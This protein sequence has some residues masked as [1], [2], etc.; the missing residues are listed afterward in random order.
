[1][2]IP[3]FAGFPEQGFRFLR[4]L[5]K[6]NDRDW[7]RERKADY[8]KYVEDPMKQLVMAV[9]ESCRERGLPLH[10]KEKQPVFRV[11]R[12]IRFSKDKSPYKTHVGAE[13]RRSF[14]DSE[15]LLYIHISPEECFTAA[16]LW[17]TSKGLLQVLRTAMVRDPQRFEKVLSALKRAKLALS[18]NYA[19]SGMPRGLQQYTDEPIGRWLKL[20]SFI[21]QRPL[22]V[23][24]CP[25]ARLV[26][27][28]VDFALT[29]KPLFEFVWEIETEFAESGRK[30]LEATLA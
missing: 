30:R 26:E 5:K 4:Q 16:G 25:S 10:A 13:L 8:I 19:L 11:Y 22:S 29:A 15:C 2:A 12:D 28:I 20:T 3:E 14:T 7:F 24:D 23:K 17:Q 9:G 27:T 21:V 6:N 1:M 18:E